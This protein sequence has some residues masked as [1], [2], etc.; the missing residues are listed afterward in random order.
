[1][2][3]NYTIIEE[4]K[5]SFTL[6]QND[7][8]E[9]EFI[10]IEKNDLKIDPSYK[11]EIKN[12]IKLLQ[13]MNEISACKETAIAIYNEGKK[14]NDETRIKEINLSLDNATKLKTILVDYLDNKK[15]FDKCK[16]EIKSVYVDFLQ[17]PDKNIQE[18]KQGFL[19]VEIP[20][21]K[22]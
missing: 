5:N 21:A 10:D 9:D 17:N 3:Q 11:S 7:V 22:L 18:H 13:F 6:K 1:M 2:E 8:S 15:S 19:N 12:A 20:K 14:S 16:N 4:T